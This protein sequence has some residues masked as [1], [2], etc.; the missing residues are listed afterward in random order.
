MDCEVQVDGRVDMHRVGGQIPDQVL[1]RRVPLL[2][3]NALPIWSSFSFERWQTA[4]MW[5]WDA[6]GRWG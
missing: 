3:P 4:Y 6:A 2:P 1:K 5:A